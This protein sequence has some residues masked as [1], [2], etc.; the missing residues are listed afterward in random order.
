MEDI[1]RW[2]K[3]SEETPKE[4]IFGESLEVLGIDCLRV[5]NIYKNV[6]GSWTKLPFRVT[7]KPPI[8]WHY[9]PQRPSQE[10]IDNE[11]NNKTE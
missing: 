3:A 4:K 8:Y 5:R 11:L 1:F 10:E 7:C 2:R 6:R 9:L